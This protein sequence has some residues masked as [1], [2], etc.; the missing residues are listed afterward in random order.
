MWQYGRAPLNP[1]FGNTLVVN[2]PATFADPWATYAGGDPF[3]IEKPVPSNVTYPLFGSFV[4]MPL[5]VKPTQLLQFNVSYERQFATN[6]LISLAYIGNRTNHLWLGKEI[7]PGIYIP[8]QS[9]TSNVNT[10]RY[11]YLTNPVAGPV[12]R[13][14]PHHRRRRDGLV[15]RAR[16]RAQPPVR[17]QLEPAVELHLEQVR[18]RRRPRHRHHQLL[19]RSERPQ[20]QP[21][22]LQLG[23][24]VHVQRV[25]HLAKRRCREAGSPTR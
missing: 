3:P 6:W 11:L 13:R 7:N 22:A 16:R 21:R 20:H 15:Q 18:Q 5:D 4:N 17:R 24:P 2:N 9:T 23:S 12:L 8:G 10:R 14:R 19:S 25:G 1:P